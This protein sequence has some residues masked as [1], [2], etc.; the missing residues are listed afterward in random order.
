MILFDLVLRRR[1]LE[2]E[3]LLKFLNFASHLIM[4]SKRFVHVLPCKSSRKKKKR[5]EKIMLD[6]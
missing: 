5:N 6:V 3:F 1:R 4:L 2:I